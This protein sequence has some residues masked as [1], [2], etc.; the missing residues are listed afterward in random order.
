MFF[1][2]VLGR[3][4][5]YAF[6]FTSCLYYSVVALSLLHVPLITYYV[7]ENV[8]HECNSSTSF[9]IFSVTIAIIGA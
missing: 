7:T 6:D 8:V 1:L 4:N 3:K 2:M 9:I 5:Y